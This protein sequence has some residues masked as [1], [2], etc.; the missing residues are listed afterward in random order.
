MPNDAFRIVATEQTERTIAKL[1][2][3]DAMPQLRR[4]M[5]AATQ[6]IVPAARKA[7]RQTPSRRKRTKVDSLR[8]AVAN[9]ITRKIKLS[10]RR[11]MIVIVSIPHGGKSNLGSVLEGDKPW[12]HPTYG[13]SPEVDQESHPFF[14]KTIR[15]YEAPIER[16]LQ[17][18]LT[19]FEKRL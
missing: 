14:A 9:S 13:H 1:K 2:G 8:T 4:E 16:S 6:P 5:R 12:R 15:R 3:S 11:V 7:A 17:R 18:V 19:E 10:T